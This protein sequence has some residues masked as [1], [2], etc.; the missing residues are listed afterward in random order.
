MS[1]RE[2]I[3]SLYEKYGISMENNMDVYKHFDEG[4]RDCIIPDGM[5][6]ESFKR[7]CRKA[8]LY[9]VEK[10][11]FD[12]GEDDHDVIKH[13]INLAKQKQ[14]SQDLLRIE[15]KSFREANRQENALVEFNKQLIEHLSNHSLKEFT[16]EHK[17]E[18][19][20]YYG[21]IQLSDLHLNELIRSTTS[22]RNSFDFGV[23]AK[24][25]K[26]LAE[27]AKVVF[28]AHGIKHVLLANTGDFCNSDRRLD[29]K[30]SMATNRTAATLLSAYLLEQF[31]LDLNSEYNLTIATVVGNE[32]RVDDELA[33]SEIVANNNYDYML[34]HILRLLFRGATGVDFLD[35]SY[36]EKVAS[37]GDFN[38]LLVH[39][40]NLKHAS[41]DREI[42]SKMA[43]YSQM[44]VRIDYV[45]YGHLHQALISDWYARSSSLCG[46]NAYS[47]EGLNLMGKASQNIYIIQPTKREVHAMK[48]DLQNTEGVVG[49]NIKKELEAYNSKSADKLHENRVIVQVVI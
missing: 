34:D 33:F 15:R 4:V 21:V 32:S 40:N 20:N 36:I 14:R 41:I 35:G 9:L 38:I 16:K 1:M 19:S 43:K 48:V 10:G 47:N 49:Y 18:S 3:I 17:V 28:K 8:R 2:W 30:L 7:Q 44:G 45:M 25:L 46:D 31:I 26:K 37:M 11:F 24:R 13:N 23:A 29:E 27:H 5:E 39:G 22:L 6:K 42:Y 12:S